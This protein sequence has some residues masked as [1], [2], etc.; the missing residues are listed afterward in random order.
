MKKIICI[1]LSLVLILSICSFKD[2]TVDA[3]QRS[4]MKKVLKY[5]KAKKYK[6]ANKYAKKLPKYA[7]ERCVKNM[8][9]KM[10][11]A[12]NSKFNKLGK[13]ASEQY[14]TDVNNDKKADM[15]V[16]Y[17][18]CEA[19]YTTRLYMY[20]KGKVVYKAK[21]GGGHCAY[22]AYPNHK[23]FIVMF[24]HMASEALSVVKYKKG[25][26]VVKSYGGR[27]VGSG[28]YLDLG[29]MLKLQKFKTPAI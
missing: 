1:V 25:K 12:Y 14:F 8:P 27:E 15:L 17:G 9:K 10:K 20:K 11:R 22:F 5:Y 4:N 6:K 21:T 24:A 26:F 7:K 16:K 2:E 28:S 13:K 29:C 19:D 3:S 23:G 18:T